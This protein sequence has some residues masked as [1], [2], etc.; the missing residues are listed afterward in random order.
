MAKRRSK[1]KRGNFRSNI[2]YVSISIQQSRRI[3]YK[4]RGTVPFKKSFR[5]VAKLTTLLLLSNL[6]TR[7]ITRRWSFEQ[8]SLSFQNS[9]T[10]LFFLTS[11]VTFTIQYIF[12]IN[13]ISYYRNYYSLIRWDIDVSRLISFRCHAISID[14][15]VHLRILVAIYKFDEIFEKWRAEIG[16]N[17]K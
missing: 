4:H 8:F 1:W 15:I 6:C 7:S 16:M 11:P 14:R 2:R 12:R 9:S 17:G 5:S 3:D 13:V 10:S